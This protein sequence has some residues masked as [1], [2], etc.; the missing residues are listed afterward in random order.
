MQ[1]DLGCVY[2]KKRKRDIVLA[3]CIDKEIG[4]L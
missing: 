2:V 4:F 3:D 1:A